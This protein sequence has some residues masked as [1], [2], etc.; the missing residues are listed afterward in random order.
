MIRSLVS[1]AGV[2][3]LAFALAGCGG[4]GPDEGLPKG[5]TYT[6]PLENPSMKKTSAADIKKAST[7]PPAGT[8]AK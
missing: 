7:P 8:P 1:W 2:V 4:S 5:A 6:P 3:A